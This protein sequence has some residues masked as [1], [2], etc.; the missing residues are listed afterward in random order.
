[1][2]PQRTQMRTTHRNRYL[3]S[4][5]ALAALA[6]ALAACGSS[7]ST[8]T[9]TT[10]VVSD[11]ASASTSPTSPATG[12]GRFKAFRECL[13]KNGIT[14]PQRSKGQNPGG[15][16]GF[17][18]GGAPSGSNRSQYEAAIK[19]CGGP[20]AGHFHR[21][22]GRPKN[23]QAFAAFATCMRKNGVALPEPNTSGKGPIFDTKGL[24]MASATFR[25]AEQKCIADLHQAFR[26]PQPTPT[27]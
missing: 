27:G 6:L 9:K 20:A 23:A 12:S 15:P 21:F 13:A 4:A 14:L 18:G 10:T 5:L 16:G 24:N 1:M 3:A 7:N 17:L 2:E 22:A 25:A 26:R 19:K 8:S 11:S